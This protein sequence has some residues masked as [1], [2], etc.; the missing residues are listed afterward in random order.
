MNERQVENTTAPAASNKPGRNKPKSALT[1]RIASKCALFCLGAFLIWSFSG[2]LDGIAFIVVATVSC[3]MAFG[4]AIAGVTLGIVSLCRL[5]PEEKRERL[6]TSGTT[7]NLA[8][9]G[10]AMPPMI[11]VL[12]FV[13]RFIFASIK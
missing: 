13:L 5:T 1:A 12:V 9:A 8:A 11:V 3:F 6:W 4:L 7:K 10:I 2:L